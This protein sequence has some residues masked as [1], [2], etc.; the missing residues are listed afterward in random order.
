MRLSP[1]LRERLIRTA[2]AA[3]VAL[4]LAIVA[5]AAPTPAVAGQADLP[6]PGAASVQHAPS[7]LPR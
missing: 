6:A 5:L 2:T 7:S 4:A 1:D 3:G